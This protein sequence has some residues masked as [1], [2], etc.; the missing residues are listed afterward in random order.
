MVDLD[1]VTGFQLRRMIKARGS[2]KYVAREIELNARTLRRYCAKE[3]VPEWLVKAVRSVPEAPA[4]VQ[5]GR[6]G[7]DRRG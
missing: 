6:N 2:Q 3:D 4:E 7:I 5:D 1:R